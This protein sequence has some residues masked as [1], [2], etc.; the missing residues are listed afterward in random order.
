MA[1]HDSVEGSA[2]AG[3][4]PG[5]PPKGEYITLQEMANWLRISRGSA[6][7][8]VFEKGE[9]P[10]LRIGDRMVRLARADVED[11]LRR[12]RSDSV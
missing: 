5:E 11:Y 3:L 7:S 2:L 6:W 8:L 1:Q 12:C 4:R 10:H 9:I